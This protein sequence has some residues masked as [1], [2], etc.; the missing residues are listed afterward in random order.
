MLKELENKKVIFFDMGY[1][2][3][4]PA[5]GD[6][7]HTKKFYEIVGDKINSVSKQELLKAKEIGTD[8]LEKHHI[9]KTL[10]EEYEQFIVY[11]SMVS[12]LLKFNLTEKEI[13]TLAYD[14]TYNM[15]NYILFDDAIEVLEVLSK[16]YKLGI[17]SDTWPSIESQLMKHGIKKYFATFTYSCDLGVFKPNQKMYL[18]AL[19]KAKCKGEEA[20]FIDDGLI[21]IEGAAKLGITPILITINPESNVETKLT[22]IKSLSDLI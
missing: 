20:V 15:D 21:N 3:E 7:F 9:C 11:Y 8:W 22:K 2:L 4:A 14:K 18:D 19:N 1:T 16:Q 12:D 5:S 10:N 17:I 13:Q 6:W